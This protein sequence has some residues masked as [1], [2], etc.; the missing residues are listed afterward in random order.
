MD[1]KYFA[2]RLIASRPDF[3]MTMTESERNIMKE[4]IAYWKPLSEAGTM[5]VFGP[6]MDPSG[7]YGLG[8]IAASDINEAEELVKADP[9]LAISS[10]ELHQIMAVVSPKFSI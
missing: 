7:V 1:K 2:F 6:V 10:Y 5:L 9:A 3:A 4:H 8:I